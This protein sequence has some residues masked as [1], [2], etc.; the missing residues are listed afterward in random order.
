M[1]WAFIKKELLLF[2]RNPRELLVLLAL[3]FLLITILGFALGGIMDGERTT[4]NGK[5]AIVEHGSETEDFKEWQTYLQELELPNEAQQQLSQAAKELL[6]MKIL[7][8]SVLGSREFQQYM[9]VEERSVEELAELKADKTF[10]AI[11]EVPEGYTFQMLQSILL[12]EQS[13]VPTMKIFV[14]EGRQLTSSI[15]EDVL[16]DFQRQYSLLTL[17][18]KSNL[19]ESDFIPS[20]E[21]ET[22]VETVAER[23]SFSSLSYFTVGMS[24]M[25]VLYVASNIGSF[26]YQEKQWNV[27]DRILLSNV[28]KWVYMFSLMC[29]AM[30]LVIVQLTIILGLS[31]IIYGVTW[32][33]WGNVIVIVMALSFAVGGVAVLLTAIN[34]RTNSETFSSFFSTVVVTIFAFLG[35]SFIP[36][37]NMSSF[38][39]VLG[40]LTPNGAAMTAF[41]QTL[42]GYELTEISKHIWSMLLFGFIMIVISIISFPKKGE[43]R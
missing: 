2:I 39:S 33:N 12:E 28:S 11:I 19:V 29:A 15:V 14:N 34:F 27:F 3:P 26:S 17:L 41:L 30:I 9:E 5:M 35:G 32:P 24:M 4:L 8:E 38:L 22:S 43:L 36:V 42:Q 13:E 40:N 25:F 21:V 20:V 31:A 16:V 23:S 10:S 1:L 37:A 7:K 6:P 18:G